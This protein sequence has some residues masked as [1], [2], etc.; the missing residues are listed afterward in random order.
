MDGVTLYHLG[1]VLRY[2]HKPSQGVNVVNRKVRTIRE[3][4]IIKTPYQPD[5]TETQVFLRVPPE[6]R[7]LRTRL[8]RSSTW[9]L[10]SATLFFIAIWSD[11]VFSIAARTAS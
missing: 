3:W 7:I 2:K 9:G 10:N 11:L 1:F 6:I 8:L 4:M 5:E